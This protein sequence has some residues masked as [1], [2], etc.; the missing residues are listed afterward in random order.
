MKYMKRW[1]LC[2]ILALSLLA[3]TATAFGAE[4]DSKVAEARHG[5]VRILVEAADGSSI[6]YGTG[7]GVGTPGKDTDTFVTNW[8]VV[9]SSGRF[10]SKTA[11]VY[12][13][14]DDET[15]FRIQDDFIVD[16][17]TGDSVECEVLYAE[18]E[19]PDVAVIR[20]SEPLH[21]VKAMPLRYVSQKDIGK[22]VYAI[23]YPGSAD[24]GSSEELEDGSLLQKLKASVEAVTV[25]GGVISKCAPLEA[26]GNTECIVHDAHINHGN[27]G[28]PLIFED[29]SVIGINTYGYGEVA[30]EYSASIYI[31]YATEVLDDLG[32]RYAMAGGASLGKMPLGLLAVGVVI[33]LVILAVIL[34][35]VLKK[36]KLPQ[37][38]W[39]AQIP[40]RAPA[41]APAAGGSGISGGGGSYADL[42]LQGVSGTFSGR[43]FQ[44]KEEV[45]MG[46]N[47]Q[48]C[49]FV[50]P[51]D[52]KGISGAHC[53]IRL[54]NSGISITDSG[55]TCGTTVNGK[56]LTPNQPCRLSVGDRI[57]L[58]SPKEEFQITRKGGVT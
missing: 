38:A 19:F 33:L 16:M 13:L 26:F 53:V 10:D 52:T 2:M 45:R 14:L 25:T 7:F 9:T 5:V 54:D 29:G 55:S 44:L 34:A 48:C 31:K 32:I 6:S 47:P 41:Q 30:G 12:I 3:G 49:N 40:A 58:G 15:W 27:S 42:R 8:H 46:R 20:T 50:Y 24:T 36:K 11:R 51:T 57:C 39:A 37:A 43:R 21:N 17:E 1:T 22:S 56:K 23:G 35:V 18:Q 4:G 28:G